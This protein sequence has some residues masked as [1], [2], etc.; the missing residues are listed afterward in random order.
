MIRNSP[1]PTATP[2]NNAGT[3]LADRG[4]LQLPSLGLIYMICVPLL[5]GVATIRGIDI[6]GFN[7][8][9][10]L[11]VIA[12]GIGA[13]LLVVELGIR[14]ERRNYF[15]IV[16]WAIWLVYVGTSFAWL[17][18]PSYLQ[19][20]YT[21]QLAMPVL[22]GVLASLFV[23]SRRRLEYLIRAYS[24]SL[25]LI[26]FFVVLCVLGVLSQDELDPV[27]VATRPLSMTAAVIGGLFLA[28]SNRKFARSWFGWAACLAIAVVTASRMASLAILLLP[29]L[30]PLT[31]NPLRR[32]A[33]ILVVGLAVVAL[34]ETQIFQERFFR[35]ES[36]SASQIVE[37]DFDSQGRFVGW[38]FVLE[39]AL[40]QPWFGHGVGSVQEFVPKVWEGALHPCNDYLRVGYEFG[41]VGLVL[42]L[43]V[44]GWQLWSLGRQVRRTDG[45]V[46]QAFAGAWL[47][48]ATFLLLASTDNPIVY[49][50]WYMNPVF[51][52]IGA[53]YAV[54]SREDLDS[55]IADG[56]AA[57][58]SR[59][60]PLGRQSRGFSK[61]EA[62]P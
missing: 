54:A 25:L 52:L 32:V 10:V 62:T 34:Y 51:A 53:A 56:A 20:Q 60:A 50:L 61:E 36:G 41:G 21:M 46:Q 9:G 18:Q 27:F 48:L 11:W 4:G 3:E 47:G 30:N 59:S 45:A 22:V 43:G 2:S 37:G 26:A 39:E 40:K 29:V 19:V 17:D 13:L 5:A 7:Y 15:P 16:P 33:M 12:L 44:M 24:F 31:V 6:A 58:L 57:S 55:E 38:P 1:P 8:S 28:G 35:G 49:H 14:P 23:G 42:F